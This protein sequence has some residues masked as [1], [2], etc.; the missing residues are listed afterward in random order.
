VFSLGVSCR[1][2][3][4]DVVTTVIRTDGRPGLK[5]SQ[6]EMECGADGF[7]GR[8]GLDRSTLAA[9]DAAEARDRRDQVARAAMRERLALAVEHPD[10]FATVLGTWLTGA[11]HGQTMTGL[12]GS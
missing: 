11:L 8:A 6:H 1:A 2:A 10:R 4:H 9:L 7:A 5:S 3:A 12:S